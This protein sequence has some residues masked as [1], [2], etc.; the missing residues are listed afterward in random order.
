MGS[1]VANYI[2]AY[3]FVIKVGHSRY[4]EATT[5]RSDMEKTRIR[6]PWRKFLNEVGMFHRNSG[7]YIDEVQ[8]QSKR[9]VV[10]E[11]ILSGQ[12]GTLH[13]A[14]YPPELAFY[15]DIRKEVLGAR[16]RHKELIDSEATLNNTTASYLLFRND[17]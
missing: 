5:C 12:D 8:Q 11:R 2:I 1:F 16:L 17:R 13:Y 3:G 7:Y 4:F 15:H 6:K 14:W 10:G 9:Y